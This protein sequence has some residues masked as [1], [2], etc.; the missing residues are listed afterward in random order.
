MCWPL[1]VMVVVGS[2][3]EAIQVKA[4]IDYIREGF[5][6]VCGLVDLEV[7]WLPDRNGVR[8]M[9]KAVQPDVFHFIGH[10][11]F[12]EDIGGYLRL[13]QED[14]RPTSSGR[15]RPSG[16]TSPTVC[17]ASRCSTPAS[18]GGWKSTQERG[19]PREA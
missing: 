8:N 10:G 13:Q 4:E 11:D 18:P 16:L 14:G 15:R 5:R 9:A 3:D 17:R 7:A 19:R 1:R 2:H 12:D 6:K